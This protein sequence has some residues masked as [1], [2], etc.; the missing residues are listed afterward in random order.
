MNGIEALI[1]LFCYWGVVYYAMIEFLTD[2]EL[3]NNGED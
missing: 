2:G 3:R 1:F